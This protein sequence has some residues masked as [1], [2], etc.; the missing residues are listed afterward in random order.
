M[1]I[2]N[3]AVEYIKNGLSVHLLKPLEKRPINNGWSKA[4]FLKEVELYEEFKTC[5]DANIGVRLGECSKIGSRYLYVLDLDISSDKPEKIKE[6]YDKL[7][8]IYKDYDKLPMVKSA[9][10]NSRHFY[11]LSK[12]L[13]KTKKLG[14]SVDKV[15]VPIN[16]EDKVKNAWEI[17]LCSTGKQVV[18]PPSKFNGNTYQWDRDL[19]EYLNDDSKKALMIIDDMSLISLDFENDPQSIKAETTEI[20]AYKISEIKRYLDKLPP[21][22][23]DNY[24]DWLKVGMALHNEFD[25]TEDEQ[26]AIQLYDEFSKKSD[27]YQ[28]GAAYSKWKS[29]IKQE[30]GI[31]L[32]TIFFNVPKE[33][34]E[35]KMAN[36]SKFLNEEVVNFKNLKNKLAECDLKDYELEPLIDVI[37]S[38]LSQSMN[39]KFSSVST[40]KVI[41]ALK[42]EL[43]EDK[44]EELEKLSIGL[45]DTLATMILKTDFNEGKHLLNLNNNL[46]VYKAGSWVKQEMAVLEKI[47]LNGIKK[48]IHSNDVQYSSIKEVIYKKKKNDDMDG[49]TNKITSLI[50]KMV[51]TPE[52]DD[53]LNLRNK[54]EVKHSVVNTLNKEIYIQ[55]GKMT[56]EDHKYDSYLI[57]KY[58]VNYLPGEECPTWKMVLNNV[59]QK[60]A[61]KEEMIRHFCEV[62]GYILQSRKKNPVF[63]ILLGSGR[64]GKSFVMDEFSKLMGIDSTINE[65][66]LTFSSSTHAIS[67]LVGKNMFIDDD[68]KKGQLLPDDYI[69]KLSENKTLTANPKFKERFN[70][71]SRCTPV[72][73]AN[74]SPKTKD[75][76]FG[77]ERRAHVFDFT[78][79]FQLSEI[80]Y[81]LDEKLSAERSGFLNMLLEHYINYEKR[82]SFKIPLSCQKSIKGWLKGSNPLISFLDE[83]VIITKD[84]SDKV[85]AQKLYDMYMMYIENENFSHSMTRNNFKDDIRHIDGLSIKRNSSDKNDYIHGLKINNLF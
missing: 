66:L 72:I 57:T 70:F 45:D 74:N 31:T 19:L 27:K 40:R 75:T 68:W 12:V 77:L 9:S 3:K 48:I 76:S 25:E 14:H 71:V 54:N 13:L 46:F 26:D 50:L 81:R 16:G 7:K 83:K 11:F 61:D 85:K 64:N 58:N 8:A 44:D 67:D 15:T 38:S 6:A 62:L 1:Q 20:K 10:K 18:I 69:K 36:F 43:E 53:I 60:Y 63:L 24:D 4:P 79:Q 21:E 22:F 78:Y 84:T 28:K 73:L 59:F 52:S 41:N 39:K 51:A 35:D 47:V 42:K 32:G 29:F 30:G 23:H 5:P 55:N 17:D 80:D 49:L 33:T 82:G 2:Y 65:D 37:A 34:A 56:V